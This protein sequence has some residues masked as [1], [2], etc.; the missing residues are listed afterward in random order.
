[1]EEKKTFSEVAEMWREYKRRY[2]KMST[3][4][5]YVL[6]LEKHL[7]P[8]FGDKREVNEEMVTAFAA[9]KV[10]QGLSTKTVK[11]LLIVLKM[12]I[13]YGDRHHWIDYHEWEVKLPARY[14]DG[15]HLPVL[16]IPD[17]KMIAQHVCD[18]FTYSGLGI[19]LCLTTGMRI[20]EICGLKWRNVDVENGMIY[21]RQTM[22]RVYVIEDGRRYTRL[23]VDSPKTASSI[24]DIPL[25]KELVKMLRQVKRKAHPDSYGKFY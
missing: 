16:S 12:V 14:G 5:A 22:G 7:L 15:R 8:V 19:Y 25:S 24:R 1:M 2:V 6:T 3:Y 4:W 17:S 11:G 21:V 23:V 20:G 18:H 13:K 9:E 10:R